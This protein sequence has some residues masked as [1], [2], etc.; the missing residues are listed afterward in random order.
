MSN[1]ITDELIALAKGAKSPEELSE[2]ATKNGVELTG[3]EATAYFDCLNKKGELSD[4]ELDAVAG[5]GCNRKDGRLVVTVGYSCSAYLCKHC[6]IG[7]MD[8][9]C[10][11]RKEG[12]GI[13][14]HKKCNTCR[15]CSY[16]KGLWL[17]NHMDN[18]K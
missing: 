4:D 3:E 12:F 9:F 6:G 18:F 16:E 2:L 8:H 14:T 5:G 11:G 15:F 10:M 17:C 13:F 7:D 1:K